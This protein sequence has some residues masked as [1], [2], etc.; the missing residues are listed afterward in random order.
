MIFAGVKGAALGLVGGC[1]LSI[2]AFFVVLFGILWIQRILSCFR[3][4]KE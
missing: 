3:K 2:F 4:E 1:S